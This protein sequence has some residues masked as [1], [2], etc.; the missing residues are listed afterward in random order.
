[1]LYYLKQEVI[2]EHAD[3]VL[4]GADIRYLIQL[5][6]KAHTYTLTFT[7]RFTFKFTLEQI[8]AL[9]FR[10]L[11]IWMPEMEQ[12]E[13]PAG[14]W[15][16]EADRSLLA[17]VFKHG[18]S[19]SEDFWFLSKG[20]NRGSVVCSFLPSKREFLFVIA[21]TLILLLGYEMYTTMRADPC[22]CFLERAGRPDDKAIDAE[23]HTGDAELGDE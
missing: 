18:T 14:W 5:S 13:V 12:Q 22:L 3:S 9:F 7:C 23:Q 6:S 16:A 15:D 21:L 20:L 19:L 17:G 4:K 10:D 1:M 11:D 8:F 2:G